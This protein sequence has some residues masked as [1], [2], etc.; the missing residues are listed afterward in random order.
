MEITPKHTIIGNKFITTRQNEEDQ[1][2]DEFDSFFNDKDEFEITERYKKIVLRKLRIVKHTIAHGEDRYADMNSSTSS[3]FI[4][5]D[6]ERYENE[7]N[8]QLGD[9]K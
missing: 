7:I 1:K 8:V 9:I 5:D 4:H 3:I 6:I 2:D